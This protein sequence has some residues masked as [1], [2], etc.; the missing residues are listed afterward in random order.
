MSRQVYH[1]MLEDSAETAADRV[2][3]ARALS[4]VEPKV[5]ESSSSR[6][7]P[8]DEKTPGEDA[9]SAVAD[10][11]RPGQTLVAP[12]VNHGTTN[13][14]APAAKTGTPANATSDA[15]KAGDR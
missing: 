6:P 4:D 7:G 8:K 15:S 13:A 14:A 10:D 3:L 9:Q 12:V 1:R 2:S 5:R 11:A